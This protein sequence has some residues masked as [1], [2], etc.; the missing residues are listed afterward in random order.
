MPNKNCLPFG[1]RGIVNCK[2]NFSVASVALDTIR[3]Y[4]YYYYIIIMNKVCMQVGC[5][6]AWR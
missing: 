5:L 3:L 1:I 4:C 6:V 2:N